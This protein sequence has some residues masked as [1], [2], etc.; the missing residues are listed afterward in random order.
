MFASMEY[1]ICRSLLLGDFT[2]S[3]MLQL[4]CLAF[5]FYIYTELLIRNEYVS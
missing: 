3:D 4:E 2:I 5:V 1:M